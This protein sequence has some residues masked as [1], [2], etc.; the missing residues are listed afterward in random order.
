MTVGVMALAMF[1]ACQ[2]SKSEETKNNEKTIITQS[3]TDKTQL[4]SPGVITDKHHPD[5]KLHIKRG[6]TLALRTE[7]M[8]LVAVDAA[9][10]READYSVTSLVAEELPPLPQGMINMTAATAGYRLLP[11]GEHF[12]PYAELRMTYDPGR[13]P[14]GY[15][16]DDIYTSFYDT[17]TL[18]WVRLERVEV[19]TVNHEIVS[20][21][22]HF[23]DFI[24]E[25]LKAPEMPET[26]A[27][28]PTAMT[29]L[30]AVSPMDGLPLLTP[31]EANNEGSANLSYP[32]QVPSGRAG[33]QPN[34]SVTYNSGGG[35]GWLGVGWDLSVPAITLDTRWGVPRYDATFETEIYL[36]AGEQLITRDSNGNPRPMP[37]RTNNQTPRSSLGNEV[38]FFARTGDAHDSIIRHNT[39]TSDYWWEVVDRNGITHYYGHYPDSSL[40]TPSHPTT[41][42]DDRGNIAKWMLT[43]SRDPYGNWVR[44]YYDLVTVGGAVPGKQIYLE[45]I[46]YTGNNNDPGKYKVVFVRKDRNPI[47]IPVSC[48][49]GFK[50][51]TDQELCYI[52]TYLDSGSYSDH[53]LGNGYYFEKEVKYGSNYKTRLKSIYMA[54]Y[55]KG[56]IIKWCNEEGDPE[57]GYY[58]SRQDFEY[59]DTPEPDHLFS[60]NQY[61]SEINSEN[62]SAFMLMPFSQDADV[63]SA[64]ALGLTQSA[65]WNVGG[66]V[67]V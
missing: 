24:N 33:M 22:T 1:S 11:G 65:N 66:T 38:R 53:D 8:T 58:V 30:E 55:D 61:V 49:L 64:T 12:L 47:D 40:N 51:V 5:M 37:H 27:F 26:K 3:A 35:N 9:V 39:L 23:T 60:A 59:Y 14:E 56:A 32:I 17:A 41:I 44:Y 34:L 15:T 7:G 54:P 10:Q 52:R 25:L 28:V 6:E 31:P 4:D 16:P 48:N 43:E 45:H 29:D 67:G 20:L 63:T 36:L 19:D 18:S 62:I 50:E 13:L 42:G 57:E 21:T 46:E 2:S